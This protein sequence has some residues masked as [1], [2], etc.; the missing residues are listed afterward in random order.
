MNHFILCKNQVAFFRTHMKLKN[1]SKFN[2]QI[3][4]LGK[5]KEIK[6]IQKR[7][8]E[9]EKWIKTQ[10]RSGE[11]GQKRVVN[12]K[13][14]VIF[15]FFLS[16]VFLSLTSHKWNKGNSFVY[17]AEEDSHKIL[18]IFIFK[19]VFLVSFLIDNIANPLNIF[20][21]I[22]ILDK[23]LSILILK[24]KIYIIVKLLLKL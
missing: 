23:T 5:K 13:R 16:S 11:S 21:D 14:C 2:D 10:C 8:R 9:R 20:Y 3:W 4:F 12:I 15:F 17:E 1:C 18:S 7:E 22:A 6:S 19:F 24:K